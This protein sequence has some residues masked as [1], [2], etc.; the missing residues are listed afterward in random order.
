M[1]LLNAMEK[2]E[3]L[4]GSCPREAGAE[5]I[6]SDEAISGFFNLDG[7]LSS[8]PTVA[9]G[10]AGQVGSL[11]SEAESEACLAATGQLI[12]V[13]GEV[14]LGL[15]SG[16]CTKQ[17]TSGHYQVKVISLM[18][19]KR[20]NT[21]MDLKETRRARLRQVIDKQ[22]GGVDAALAGKIS[23]QASYIS[24]IFSENPAHRRNIGEA[25]ARQIETECGL[26][27]G[28]LDRPFEEHET[29][30]EPLPFVP[31][32]TASYT[33]EPVVVWDDETPLSDDEVE[34]PFLKEVELSAGT[35]RYAITEG[36]GRKLRFGRYT[37]RNR[38]VDPANAVAVS[39]TGNSMEPV[40]RNGATVGVDRGTT[41]VSDGDL[42]AI[43][44]NGELRVKQVYRLPGGG[45]RLRS[46]NRDEH[47]DEEYSTEDMASK[48]IRIL[49]R[50]WWGAM[51]F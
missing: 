23:R 43:D 1:D 5:L 11:D 42:Y 19:N 35:G 38:G 45:I 48:R 20:L 14:H 16:S 51:F 7:P 33:L 27:P 41:T 26:E 24:R 31:K 25:L 46:F 50:V 6:T 2:S 28:F 15:P 10:E 32:P 21:V 9:R 4:S 39:V 40:L 47:P 17:F 49:G 22:F 30:A 44:H 12:E 29:P 18:V 36:S 34:I 37:M 13:G 3:G 8:D